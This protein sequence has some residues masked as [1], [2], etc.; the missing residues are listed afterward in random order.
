MI[1]EK[2]AFESLGGG[3][4]VHRFCG[5][6]D[7]RLMTVG[8][9]T[10][11]AKTVTAGG[12]KNTQKKIRATSKELLRQSP[13][14]REP[15]IMV[16]TRNVL[17]NLRCV[18]YTEEKGLRFVSDE[19]PPS[20]NVHRPYFAL[21]YT[22]EGKFQMFQTHLAPDELEPY[23]WLVTGVPVVWDDFT[24]DRLYRAMVTEAADHSHVFHLPR[25]HHF[26]IK[27]KTIA[28][29][30]EL[31]QTFINTLTS[32]RDEAFCKLSAIADKYG[33]R[34]ESGYLHNVLCVNSEGHLCQLADKDLLESLGKRMREMFGC[35]RAICV[36]NGGSCEVS[37]FP[38][39][40]D[41]PW[42]IKS[43]FGHRLNGTAYLALQLI[44]SKFRC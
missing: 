27:E 5:V 13:F 24:E 15:A 37:F 22:K 1:D 6:I 36:D 44:N 26:G 17:S 38:E 23:R 21:G 28:I 10:I 7:A 16:S 19:I 2:Y 39:G 34:R 41:G 32:S 40:I 31:H 30:N 35:R 33:L 12:L 4:M 14:S 20:T 9:G 3:L 8:E 25:G 11:E 43:E 42:R 18:A 29:W